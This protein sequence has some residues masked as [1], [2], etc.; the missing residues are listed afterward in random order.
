MAR[1]KVQPDDRVT[2]ALRIPKELHQRLQTAAA[3]RRIGINLLVN[4][5]LEE[6]LDELLPLDELRSS[7]KA[8]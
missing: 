3:E 4:W 7:I 2:T 1:P 8:S 6:Y 5:A